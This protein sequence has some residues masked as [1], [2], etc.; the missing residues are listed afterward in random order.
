MVEL[1]YEPRSGTTGRFSRI[2][3]NLAASLFFLGFFAMGS[4]FAVMI[5]AELGQGL[6]QRMWK[7]VP[8]TI[9]ANE[10]QNRS[11]SQNPYAFTVGYTY[12]SNGRTYSGS[13]YERRY[14][15]SEKYS[16][17]QKLSRKY[18]VGSTTF[19]YVNPKSPVDAVLKRDSLALG[20]FIFIP[21]VFVVIGAG[22]LYFTWRPKP[23]TPKSEAATPLAGKS[24]KGGTKARYVP[25]A[26]SGIFALVGLGMFYPLGIVPISRTI[27]ARSWVA[28]PCKVL[29]AEVRSHSDEDGTTY[30]VYVLYEYTVGGKPCKSDTY[31][32]VGG[33]SSGYD[34]K[35]RVV[36]QY[37]SSTNSICY[38]NPK[39]PYQAVLKRGIHAGLLVV[40]I[41][42]VFM[43]LGFGGVYGVLR[44]SRRRQAADGASVLRLM[45]SG[46]V[47]LKP[48]CS[49]WA[50]LAGAI[51][52]ALFWNGIVSVFVAQ[53]IGGFRSGHPDWFLTLF[54]VPFEI[55]GV[56]ILGFVVYQFLALFNP[57]STLELSSA[58]IPLGG[59]AELRWRMSGR[60]ARIREFTV[61]LRGTE[62]VTYQRKTQND[63]DTA[64]EKNVFHEMELYRTSNTDEIAAGS[65]GFV[66]PRDTMYSFEA[67]NNKIIWS[68]DIHGR[69]DR[70]PDVKESFKLTVAP[71]AG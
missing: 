70:W 20:L 59:A 13:V 7:K 23:K 9:V 3:G 30:S 24:A 28:T 14:K 53:M 26:L 44:G 71:A 10:V 29:H 38:V 68:L 57:R 47:V 1:G 37:R 54:L 40:L 2:G 63:T 36:E 21:L 52:I 39:N 48:K 50:K 56:A 61:T 4:F 58:A 46:P 69:I 64:T 18:P 33:S 8:C 12:E 65:I 60:V 66:L 15:I 31:D 5:V 51:L 27:D 67:P 19:C 41:P 49:P 62:E 32:F 6:H 17:A 55:V 42:V 22:G 34:G 45:A 11:D 25:A 16:E 43:L 35:A